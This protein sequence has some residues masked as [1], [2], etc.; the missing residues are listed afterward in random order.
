MYYAVVENGKDENNAS[1]KSVVDSP[2]SCIIGGNTLHDRGTENGHNALDQF[3]TKPRQEDTTK[4]RAF[5]NTTKARGSIAS[6]SR[7]QR[8]PVKGDVTGKD[9]FSAA[10]LDER[11][12][13]T[14]LTLISPPTLLFTTS[15]SPSLLAAAPPAKAGVSA[16]GLG[17]LGFHGTPS[18]GLGRKG[19]GARVGARV[20]CLYWASREP[21]LGSGPGAS[22]MV[23]S[24]D[25]QGYGRDF[26]AR[27]DLLRYEISSGG[28]D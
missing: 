6:T 11:T 19:G 22:H 13:L 28:L 24:M 15:T 12:L 8:R 20:H 1:S 27:D 16:G 26:V 3:P 17:G 21:G 14:S 5:M 18:A 4:I 9:H 10:R 23:T 25:S 7:A 2:T